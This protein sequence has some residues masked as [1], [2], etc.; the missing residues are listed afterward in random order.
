MLKRIQKSLKYFTFLAT[1]LLPI[2]FFTGVI[3]AAVSGSAAGGGATTQFTNDFGSCRNIVNNNSNALFIPGKT[4]A[5]W[6]TFESTA[7][8]KTSNACC[9]PSGIEHNGCYQNSMWAINSCNTPLRLMDGCAGSFCTNGN[10]VTYK[11]CGGDLSGGT[12]ITPDTT[13]CGNGCTNGS[14][15][16]CAANS[17]QSC[18][19]ASNVCGQTNSGTRNCAGVC[20]ASTPSNAGCY[21]NPVTF[22]FTGSNQTWTVPAGV[23]SIRVKVWGA[24]GGGSVQSW[25]GAGAFAQGDLA[26][27]QGQTINIMV[28]QGGDYWAGSTY[29]GGGGSSSGPSASG[30]GRTEVSLGGNRLIGGGG[31]GAG[32]NYYPSYGLSNGGVGGYGNGSVG[33]DSADGAGGGQGGSQGGAGAGGAGA[34]GGEYGGY[35][36]GTD[37]GGFT[38]GLG[39]SG[40][41][42]YF[43][44]GGGGDDINYGGGG[45]GG[46]SS[47][48]VG[49]WGNVSF[50]NSSNSGDSDY[51]P[52]E[53][54]NGSGFL[55]T[56]VGGNMTPNCTRG[57]HGYVVIRY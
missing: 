10:V 25:G 33:T 1:G 2:M 37:G 55:K 31:G 28:G 24:G 32:G 16:A 47:A 51:N 53:S 18:V 15:N 54:C 40:G 17:G 23:T 9:V 39:G 21:A 35:G 49:S 44:G 6:N 11:G 20:S 52:Q 38:G 45:G 26:V 27:S 19:S 13:I 7:P 34:N 43:G 57:G 48:V 30:G 14:C 36:S 22:G 29:G 42:G 50:V 56:S 41:G 46:G 12:C 4:L 8:N 3:Y 5:E